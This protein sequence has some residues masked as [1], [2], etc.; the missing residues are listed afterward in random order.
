[1]SKNRGQGANK[2]SKTATLNFGGQSN[3]LWCSG[4]ENA[5]IRNMAL[6]SQKFADQVIWFSTL[7]SKKENVRQLKRALEM[8]SAL[9]M[10]VVEMN[11]GQKV[12]RF[13]AWTFM[14]KTQRKAFAASISK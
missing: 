6:E 3:E 2:S 14:D 11:Q 13:A 5:F 7:I 9:E 8:T 12:S 1:L 4:G 10:T